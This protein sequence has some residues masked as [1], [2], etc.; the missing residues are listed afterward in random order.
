MANKRIFRNEESRTINFDGATPHAPENLDYLIDENTNK[1]RVKL[2]TSTAFFF[3]ARWEKVADR[4]GNTFTSKELLINYLT[5]T[6]AP[7]EIY[8]GRQIF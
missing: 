4:D 5:E 1:L 2:K 3:N 6:F 7:F 8:G